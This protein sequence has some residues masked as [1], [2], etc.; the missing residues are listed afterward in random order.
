MFEIRKEDYAREMKTRGW[1]DSERQEW[2]GE[3]A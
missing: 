1:R 2:N 3:G